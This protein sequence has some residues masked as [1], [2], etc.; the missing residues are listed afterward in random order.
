MKFSKLNLEKILQDVSPSANLFRRVLNLRDR[1]TTAEN[2]N[3]LVK[4]RFKQLNFLFPLLIGVGNCCKLFTSLAVNWVFETRMIRVECWA[5]HQN[6]LR[7]IKI[8][9]LSRKPNRLVKVKT[10]VFAERCWRRHFITHDHRCVV[11]R[12]NFTLQPPHNMIQ[13]LW[14]ALNVDENISLNRWMKRGE[15]C[16]C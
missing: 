7:S 11:Y 12:L 5:V 4:F 15:D 10:A 8:W 1:R 6:I 9:N 14:I 13:M 2:K 3:Q 16:K